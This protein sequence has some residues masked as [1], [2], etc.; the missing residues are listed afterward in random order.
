MGHVNIKVKKLRLP[1]KK[2]RLFV[3]TTN[4][5]FL[6]YENNVSKLLLDKQETLSIEKVRAYLMKGRDNMKKKQLISAILISGIFFL[7]AACSKQ[8]E[9]NRHYGYIYQKD[10]NNFTLLKLSSKN[11]KLTGNGINYVV[12]TNSDTFELEIQKDKT[13][14][15]GKVEDDVIILKRKGEKTI[16]LT[17]GADNLLKDDQGRV[18]LPAT[19]KQVSGIYQEIER[20]IKKE[21]K[22]N[23]KRNAKLRDEK[24]F[25]DSE[26]SLEKLVRDPMVQREKLMTVLQ[27]VSELLKEKEKKG[28]YLVEEVRK[29]YPNIDKKKLTALSNVKPTTETITAKI[30][31]ARNLLKVEETYD[32]KV[33]KMYNV[34]LDNAKKVNEIPK[35]TKEEVEQS[36]LVNAEY[37]FGFAQNLYHMTM[38]AEAISLDIQS[39]QLRIKKELTKSEELP[40]QA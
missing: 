20:K 9:I 15:T 8:N 5:N 29:T 21:N 13:S 3:I 2:E 39:E 23:E 38:Q 26:K 37:N 18:F 35:V 11:N 30:N 16:S 22:K 14:L 33:N 4:V 31:K 6:Y 19:E 1:L 32:K 40:S 17:F 34:Y 28:N 10:E 25:N 7:L 24:K 12:G 36:I 27:D